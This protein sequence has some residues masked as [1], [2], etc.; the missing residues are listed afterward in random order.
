MQSHYQYIIVGAGCAGLQLAD[1]LLNDPALLTGSILII[2]ASAIHEEKTWCFWYTA[3]HRYSHLVKKSWNNIAFRASDTSV[4]AAL[5]DLCYQYISSTDFYEHQLTSLRKDARV[6]FLFEPVSSIEWN[7][8][9]RQVHTPSGI[10]TADYIFHSHHLS[11]PSSPTLWQHFLGWEI[12]TDKDLFDPATATL[13]DFSDAT[14]S[15]EVFFH[16]ILPYSSRHALVE[17]TFFSQELLD[18]AA[19]ENLLRKYIENKLTTDYQIIA[20]ETGKIPMTLVTPSPFS[21]AT[22]IIP[23][24]SAAGCIKAS[25]G[26]SFT[27]AMRHTQQII[28]YLKKE[29]DHIPS[30]SSRRFLFYDRLFL[31]LIQ[32]YPHKMPGIFAALFKRNKIQRILRFLDEATRLWEEVIIFSQLPKK[33]FLMV[34][35]NIKK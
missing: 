13:M 35:F 11:P 19:Y 4:T 33:N 18:Q 14:E 15:Q 34:L 28:A 9:N 27:R 23:I 30:P 20:K 1:A 12:K 3:Q 2:E 17:C 7:N 8:G 22:G 24:G 32:Q 29:I 21:C 5:P 16:Y 6:T 31:S 25:T 10:I 26:Y